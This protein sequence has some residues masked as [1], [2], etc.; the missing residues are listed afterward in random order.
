MSDKKEEKGKTEK[1]KKSI[2]EMTLGEV[3]DCSKKPLG[4]FFAVAA[5]LYIAFQTIGDKINHNFDDSD[6]IQNALGVVDGI[7]DEGY[8]G[9]N[10]TYEELKDNLKDG[11]T[12]FFDYVLVWQMQ[13]YMKEYVREAKFNAIKE[14]STIKEDI[15]INDINKK[16]IKLQKNDNGEILIN[17]D[18]KKETGTE[19]KTYSVPSTEE[20]KYVME[21]EE[22]AKTLNSSSRK[23]II[24]AVKEQIDEKTLEERWKEYYQNGSIEKEELENLQEQTT[25]KRN[26]IKKSIIEDAIK[27]NELIDSEFDNIKLTENKVKEIIGDDYSNIGMYFKENKQTGDIGNIL[28]ITKRNEK[29]KSE[30][31]AIIKAKV[32]TNT[33]KGEVNAS[34]PFWQK[35]EKEWEEYSNL[36]EYSKDSEKLQ[37]IKE[38]NIA[39]SIL[40]PSVGL[41]NFSCETP[42]ND[43]GYKA[44][45]D[46]L[47]QNMR[48]MR[49]GLD[50]KK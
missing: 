39:G 10:S 1:N 25:K 29:N 35:H 13:S 48:H 7:D 15:N 33:E 12:N 46:E 8:T 49:G 26:E 18:V 45:I 16:T 17:F 40:I 2:L 47:T 44:K 23:G 32:I 4:I 30:I 3:W 27:N 11:K 20:L 28:Y 6:M 19:S 14:I 42:K 24:S 21:L 38:E 9:N 36:T 34:T 31:I 43:K 5:S 37:I 22:A 41:G 50:G